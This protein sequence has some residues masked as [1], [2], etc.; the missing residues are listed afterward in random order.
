MKEIEDEDVL[1]ASVIAFAQ[2]I[3]HYEICRYG[4]LIEWGKDLGFNDAVELLQQTLGRKKMTIGCWRRSP[5]RRRTTRLRP[6]SFRR[7]PKN[8]V[9]K[10]TRQR[11][12]RSRRR[13]NSAPD[14][15]TEKAI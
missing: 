14:F 6:E 3:E 4:T 13:Y 10:I 1:D 7:S 8:A 11:A 15:C 5:D 2:T 12:S 9:E